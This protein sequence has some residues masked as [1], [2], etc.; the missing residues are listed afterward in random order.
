M[1]SI[2]LVHELIEGIHHVVMN[3]DELLRLHCLTVEI[4]IITTSH[5][6]IWHQ[7]VAFI[8]V[9]YRLDTVD[10]LDVVILRNPLALHLQPVAIIQTH[11]PQHLSDVPR[12]VFDQVELFSFL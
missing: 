4:H 9:T 6:Q 8:G 11:C 2:V 7:S 12:E 3:I 10:S 5:H 1:A